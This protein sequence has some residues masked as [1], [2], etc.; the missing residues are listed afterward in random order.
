LFVNAKAK[1]KGKKTNLLSDS[2]FFSLILSYYCTDSILYY[3][4]F[5]LQITLLYL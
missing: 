1:E 4:Y 5:T 3:Y 2:I